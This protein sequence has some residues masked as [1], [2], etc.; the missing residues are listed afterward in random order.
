MRDFH[1]KK[2]KAKSLYDYEPWR[3]TEDKFKV[4]NNHHNESI[5]ALGNGYMGLRGTL[6]EDYSGPKE[7]T[8]PGFYINGIYGSERIIYGEEAP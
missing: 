2:Y 5:F 1:Y 6:E 8:T 7:T 3:I 4:E